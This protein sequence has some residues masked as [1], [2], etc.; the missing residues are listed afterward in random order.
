MLGELPLDDSTSSSD[1]QSDSE[2][3]ERTES[4]DGCMKLN[5]T[6]VGVAEMAQMDIDLE[7]MKKDRS[8]CTQ[9]ELDKIR[10]ERNRVHAKR[11]RVKKK[12]QMEGLQ[13]TINDVSFATNT[14]VLYPLLRGCARC[15]CVSSTA[16]SSHCCSFRASPPLLLLQ[17]EQTNYEIGQKIAW[18]CSKSF[19]VTFED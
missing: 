12:A 8:E 19:R 7:L 9:Q 11:T 2:R 16:P 6:I 5:G 18:L 1:A 3:S 10:R 13:E 15:V 17:L 4:S 14:A